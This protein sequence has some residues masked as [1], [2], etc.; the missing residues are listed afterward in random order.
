M[1][2]GTLKVVLLSD[3]VNWLKDREA[4]CL[5]EQARKPKKH[6]RVVIKGIDCQWDI[7]LMDVGSL[8]KKNDGVKFLLVAVDVFSKYFFVSP[9]KTKTGKEVK[10]ALHEAFEKGRKEK[11]VV[12]T[13]GRNSPINGYIGF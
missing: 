12:L 10:T 1:F 7:D 6:G 9:L 13:K 8:P 2:Y 11:G 4:Y 3:I 5:H